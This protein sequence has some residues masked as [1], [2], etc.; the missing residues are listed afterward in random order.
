MSAV[1]WLFAQRAGTIF[2]VVVLLALIVA[3]GAVFVLTKIK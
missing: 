2:V 3:S 1:E